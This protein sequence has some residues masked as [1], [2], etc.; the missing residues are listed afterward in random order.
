MNESKHIFLLGRVSTLSVHGWPLHG[1]DIGGQGQWKSGQLFLVLVRTDRQTTDS[2]FLKSGQNPESRQDRDRKNPDKQ[3]SNS[4]FY[5]IPDGIWTDLTGKLG[6]PEVQYLKW[7]QV[8]NVINDGF[9]TTD[10]HS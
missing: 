3:K 5:K 4:I 7:G 10:I 2:Y 6:Q 8:K 1:A 9:I